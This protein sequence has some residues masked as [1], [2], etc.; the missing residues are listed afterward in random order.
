[1]KNRKSA[2]ETTPRGDEHNS[3]NNDSNITYNST[4]VKRWPESGTDSA[5]TP[6]ISPELEQIVSAWPELPEHIKVAIKA[7]VQTRSKEAE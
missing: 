6:K 2:I 7:L 1:M 5:K 4:P 3:A